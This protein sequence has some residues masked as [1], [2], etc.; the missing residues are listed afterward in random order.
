MNAVDVLA[1]P[2]T[3]EQ[4]EAHKRSRGSYFVRYED[5]LAAALARVGG[6]K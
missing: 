3:R 1:V 6:G 4:W 2:M 5:Y